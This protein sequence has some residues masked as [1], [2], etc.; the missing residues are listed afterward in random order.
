MVNLPLPLYKYNAAAV[1]L[2][3]AGGIACA[4][5]R[6]TLVKTRTYLK[7]RIYFVGRTADNRSPP[8]SALPSCLNSLRSHLKMRSAVLFSKIKA[9]R[10]QKNARLWPKIRTKDLVYQSL[11]VPI[12]PIE[13]TVLDGLHNVVF[14]DNILVLKIGRGAGNQGRCGRMPCPKDRAGQRPFRECP[15]RRRSFC[16]FSGKR[17]GVMDALQEIPQPLNPCAEFL[18]PR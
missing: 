10:P 3:A 18:L 4:D 11:F 2:P 15:V 9:L 13:R 17:S 1:C 14:V 12:L 16:K 7:K 6:K 8:V 5:R